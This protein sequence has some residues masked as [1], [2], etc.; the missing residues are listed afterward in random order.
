MAEGSSWLGSLGGWCRAC[1]FG[2]CWSLG[3]REGIE[4]VEIIQDTTSISEAK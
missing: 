1:G 4:S 2:Y 3:G